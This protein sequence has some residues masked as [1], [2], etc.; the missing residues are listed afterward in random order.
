MFYWWKKKFVLSLEDI[1]K[2]AE[3]PTAS[4][5]EKFTYIDLQI[6]FFF[7]RRLAFF[8]FLETVRVKMFF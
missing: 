5:L 7:F 8:S 4:T 1:I 2:E 6:F 3:T